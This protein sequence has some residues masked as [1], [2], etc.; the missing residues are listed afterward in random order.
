[1][2]IS[3]MSTSTGCFL[4]A[5]HSNEDRTVNWEYFVLIAAVSFQVNGFFPASFTILLYLEL[6]PLTNLKTKLN[7]M[8]YHKVKKEKFPFLFFPVSSARRFDSSVHRLLVFLIA[9]AGN[10]GSIGSEPFCRVS[11]YDEAQK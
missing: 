10:R 2:V 9:S 1:M 3:P 7:H 11:V 8:L 4:L 6:K 5:P